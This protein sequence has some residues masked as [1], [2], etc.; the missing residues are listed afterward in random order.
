MLVH[1]GSTLP[2]GYRIDQIEPSV[3]PPRLIT[4][5]SGTC[6][7][8]WSGR[9]RGIQSPESRT[10][11]RVGGRTPPEERR[12]SIRA[13]AELQTVTPCRAMDPVQEAGSGV[14]EGG[15]ITTAPPAARVPKRS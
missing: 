8:I 1:A 7:R 14:G 6:R 5:A 10:S 4:R 3:A 9:A 11:R 15:G 12:S 13:G 2:T